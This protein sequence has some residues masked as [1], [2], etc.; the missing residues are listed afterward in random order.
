[1]KINNVNHPPT[2]LIKLGIY[3]KLKRTCSFV[4]RED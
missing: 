3:G 2:Q 4:G 1:M